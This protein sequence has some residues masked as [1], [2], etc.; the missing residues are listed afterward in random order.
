[1]NAFDR[2]GFLVSALLLLT[3]IALAA[4]GGAAG[5]TWTVPATWKEQAARSMRAATYTVPAAPGDTEPAECAVYYF[6]KG[7]GGDA[8]ANITRWAG[9]FE[10]GTKPLRTTRSVSGMTIQIVEITGTYLAPSGPMM[11]SQGKKPGYTL[12]G[13]IVPAPEGS[14]FLKLTGPSRTVAASRPAF[15]ALLASLKKQPTGTST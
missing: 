3:S 14:I 10:G 6:G 15:D 11:Q 12:V 13:A 5:V 4:S 9:Q 1:M 8:E 7:Q 2:R